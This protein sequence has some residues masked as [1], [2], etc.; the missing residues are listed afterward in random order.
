MGPFWPAQKL[1]ANLKGTSV[2]LARV[3]RLARTDKVLPLVLPPKR[4]R[5][6]V[7]ER[8]AA[9]RRAAILARIVVSLHY[10]GFS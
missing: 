8:H 3:A 1:H 2:A 10:V 5:D 4:A 6:Y 7:I 9:R